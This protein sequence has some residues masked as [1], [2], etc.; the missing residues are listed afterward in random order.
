[1]DVLPPETC[2]ACG[3]TFGCGATVGQ[4]WCDMEDVPPARLRELAARHD[5]CLCPSCLVGEASGGPGDRPGIE[6][7]A[8]RRA[9]D[10]RP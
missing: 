6:V 9:A 10:A 5:R 3:R 2:E 4:C 1:V 8:G 7:V